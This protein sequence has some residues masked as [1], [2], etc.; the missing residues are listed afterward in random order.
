MKI[1][2]YS[3]RPPKFLFAQEPK[4]FMGIQKHYGFVDAPASGSRTL[5]MLSVISLVSPIGDVTD[6]KLL[7]LCRGNLFG[8][9]RPNNLDKFESSEPEKRVINDVTFAC[10]KWSGVMKANPHEEEYG[11][12]FVT[13]LSGKEVALTGIS[14]SRA[15]LSIVEA[16]SMSFHR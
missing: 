1:A 12:I 4:D 16:S 10:C 8:M 3:I 7:A 14:P 15:K 6:L 5:L 9:N 13:V 2:G 11:F